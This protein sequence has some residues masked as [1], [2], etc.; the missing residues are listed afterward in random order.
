MIG[1]AWLGTGAGLA[2]LPLL[3]PAGAGLLQANVRP[4]ARTNNSR[5]PKNIGFLLTEAERVGA[6][7]PKQICDVSVN[8]FWAHVGRRAEARNFPHLRVAGTGPTGGAHR[9]WRHSTEG[10]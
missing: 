4:A 2:A 6:A 9:A 10:D 7:G 1:P 8:C 5:L 3:S